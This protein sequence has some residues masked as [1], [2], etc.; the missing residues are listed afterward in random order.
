VHALRNVNVFHRIVRW[1][2][3][4]I[5]FLLS[6]TNDE[7]TASVEVTSTEAANLT[8]QDLLETVASIRQQAG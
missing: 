8:I 1:F 6:L 7:K 4:Y 2:V 5:D 3:S